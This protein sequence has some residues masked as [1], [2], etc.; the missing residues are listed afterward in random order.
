LFYRIGSILKQSNIIITVKYF[1]L[2]ISLSSTAFAEQ[3]EIVKCIQ[4]DGSVVYTNTGC[5]NGRAEVVLSK[6]ITIIKHE[7]SGFY[8]FNNI[9]IFSVSFILAVYLL[10]SI[11]CFLV[12]WWDKRRSIKGEWRIP[13]AHLHWL[14]L[15]GGW[16]GAFIAQRKLRHK[17]RKQPYQFVFWMIVGMHIVAWADYLFLNHSLWGFIT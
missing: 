14:E 8:L 16:P 3:G 2:I 10:M 7:D 15:L 17:N 5:E 1:L 13:E 6:P 9:P 12:Y 11:I 4:R